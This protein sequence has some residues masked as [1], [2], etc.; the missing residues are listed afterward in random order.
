MHQ[1]TMCKKEGQKKR[2]QEFWSLD[3]N[4]LINR[5]FFNWAGLVRRMQIQEQ[6][7]SNLF[8]NSEFQLKG[9]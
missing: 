3:Q 6:M 7:G 8:Q 5:Q 1:K 9:I 4:C 2:L